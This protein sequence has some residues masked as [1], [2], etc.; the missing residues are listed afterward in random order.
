MRKAAFAPAVTKVLIL[1]GLFHIVAVSA[2]M[3]D[4]I[5]STYRFPQPDITYLGDGTISIQMEGTAFSTSQLGAPVVPVVVSRM[6]VPDKEAVL[7]IDVDY[8]E[9]LPVDGVFTVIHATSPRPLS[10]TQPQE[11]VEPPDLQIYDSPNQWPTD[12]MRRAS[13]QWL[14]GARIVTTLFY[15]VRYCPAEKK[16]SYASQVTVSIYTS[17][18]SKGITESVRRMRG[19]PKDVE[20]VSKVIDNDD[21]LASYVSSRQ[22]LAPDYTRQYLII[23]T[24]ELLEAFEPLQT[25]RQSLQGGNFSVHLTTVEAIA[26]MSTGRDLPEQ[27]RNY[28]IDSYQNH[29]TEFVILGGDADQTISEQDVPFR[30]CTATVNSTTDNNIPSDYYY[31]CLDGDWN[32]NDN[33]L[34]GEKTDGI[35]GQDIDWLAEVAVGRIPADNALEAQAAIGK[36][37]S[38]E[39]VDSI[40]YQA[41]LVGEKV[42]SSDY[43]GNFLDYVHQG[44]NGIPRE[45]MYDRDFLP[46]GWSSSQAISALSSNASNVVFHVGHADTGY[47][48]RLT[49]Y[50]L[51]DIDNNVPFVLYTQG[52]YAAAFDNFSPYSGY[53]SYDSI[54]EDFVVRNGNNAVATI[55]NS[56]S[57]WFAY[58]NVVY[59]SNLVHRKFAEA[60]YQENITQI[61]PANNK[62]KENID[63]SQELYRW[64]AFELNLL[65]DPV[66]QL[67]AD[68]DPNH[69]IL[70]IEKPIEN[71]K[72]RVGQPIPINVEVVTSCGDAVPDA[73]VTAHLSNAGENLDTT[74]YDDGNHDDGSAGD[75]IYGAEWYP[76][77][78]GQATIDV[79][80]EKTDCTSAEDQVSGVILPEGIVPVARWK[81]DEAGW[82]GT[83]GEVLDDSAGSNHG[84]SY[85]GATT[86]EGKIGNAGA[87][88]GIHAK[89]QVPHDSLLE[90]GMS[91]FSISLWVKASSEQVCSYSIIL[92]KD[93][94]Y[95]S[96]GLYRIGL[97]NGYPQF[98]VQGSTAYTVTAATQITDD[99]WHHI[100]CVRNADEHKIR[101]YVD[102][103]EDAPSVDEATLQNTNSGYPL[104]FASPTLESPSQGDVSMYKGLLDDL[105]QYDVALTE[106][107]IRRLYQPA[108][109]FLPSIYLLLLR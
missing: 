69:L 29:G 79:L 58:G 15:P 45:T 47:A 37:I 13:D 94:S 4:V 19:T 97:R 104:S 89:V 92:D 99:V 33:D 84:T 107:E 5:T 100:A 8:G 30:G 34:W 24:E 3:A 76:A 25:Y 51:D 85:G 31:A 61:G 38:Y 103:K 72:S 50:E 49:Y 56:R 87:F 81:M 55:G 74:L 54:G 57:G 98:Q 11:E 12:T 73:N 41:L 91:S 52:C 95:K 109:V 21:Q 93:H 70:S 71:F 14:H 26:N 7:T 64:I 23:T 63:Y 40:P 65:G 27:I 66:T 96:S 106:K 102:G 48:L 17:P 1:W 9:F 2:S 16:L 68:C 62:S 6:F 60:V 90:F 10:D 43:G 78:E 39:S 32:S 75:G 28:I 35:D 67:R 46:S 53:V 105:R 44:M 108:K 18:K 83:P 59:A 22:F 82:N 80:A 86:M 20:A 77:N 88:D 36:L 101:I 42:S